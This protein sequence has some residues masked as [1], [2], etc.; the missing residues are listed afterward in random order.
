MIEKHS[1]GENARKQSMSM[2]S[3]GP[4]QRI[5]K[6]IITMKLFFSTFISNNVLVG[7]CVL[8]LT[9]FGVPAI[10]A[11]RNRELQDEISKR[12]ISPEDVNKALK[13]KFPNSNFPYYE[14]VNGCNNPIWGYGAWNK[15]LEGACNNHDRCYMTVG[16]LKGACDHVMRGEILRICVRR[17]DPCPTVAETYYVMVSN[18]GGEEYSISQKRQEEYIKSVYG[19]LNLIPGVWKSSEGT[20]TFQQ[21]GSNV[22]A[23]YTQDNGTIEGEVSGSILTGHW[24]ENSSLRRCSIPRNGRYHWGRVRFIFKDSSFKGLWSYCDREPSI[25][26]KGVKLSS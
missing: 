1:D 21:S 2:E 19:W 26:W 6:R 25:P 12:G 14:P 20:I 10:A 9:A 5:V 17:N 18:F 22:S 15:V 16:K 13:D 11:D 3:S 7:I 24:S 4:C 23:T 8:C